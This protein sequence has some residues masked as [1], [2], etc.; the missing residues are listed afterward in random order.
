[1]VLRNLGERGVDGGIH[2]W[3]RRQEGCRGSARHIAIRKA[4][5]VTQ[6]LGVGYHHNGGLHLEVYVVGVLGMVLLA[7]SFLFLRELPLFEPGGGY[8]PFI[9]LLIRGLL[10]AG[11]TLRAIHLLSRWLK[12]GGSQL[13]L[14]TV[15]VPLGGAMRAELIMS[16]RIRA[17]RPVRVRLQCMSAVVKQS[18]PLTRTVSRV[19]DRFTDYSV[20]WEDEDRLQADGSGRL[21][22]AFALP[23]DQPS[24]TLPNGRDWRFWRLVAEEASG[25]TKGY[26]AEFELPVFRAPER[27]SRPAHLQWPEARCRLHAGTAWS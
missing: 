5:A 1:M 25:R 20:V 16:K 8:G 11:L 10:G 18:L 23:P 13:R 3:A 19:E 7:L 4:L 12:Y 9:P 2:S 21:Q 15:P 24:T 27:R 14:Q 17:G 6:R 22:I 26:H